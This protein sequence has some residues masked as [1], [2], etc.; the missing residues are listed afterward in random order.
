MTDMTTT[1][2]AGVGRASR[3]QGVLLPLLLL[4]SAVGAAVTVAGAVY[5]LGYDQVADA[6][7]R[8][9]AGFNPVALALASVGLGALAG[10]ATLVGSVIAARDR[11]GGQ[12]AATLVGS[13]LAGL[14]LTAL[15]LAGQAAFAL[16]GALIGSPVRRL[17]TVVPAVAVLSCLVVA[18]VGVGLA[19]DRRRRRVGLALAIAATALA[20]ALPVLNTV[21]A[22]R[23]AAVAADDLPYVLPEEVPED[24]A[25]GARLDPQ[26]VSLSSLALGEVYELRLPFGEA[27]DAATGATSGDE[28]HAY[29]EFYVML[30]EHP[31]CDR[32]RN[33][34]RCELVERDTVVKVE[35]GVLVARPAPDGG[36]YGVLLLDG[37]VESLAPDEATVARVRDLVEDLRVVTREEYEETLGVDVT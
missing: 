1:P 19:L 5:L 37:G 17:D 31:G 33:A 10:I 16:W 21:V 25:Q 24:L 12:A 11:L 28:V 14:G 23:S 26:Q 29:D 18:P 3:A 27:P 6:T 15:A 20:I 13:C 36:A 32:W 7:S 9:S 8:A 2:P 4:M 22:S 34:G 35:A 30:S